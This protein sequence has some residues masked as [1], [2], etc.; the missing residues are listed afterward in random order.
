MIKSIPQI[1]SNKYVYLFKTFIIIVIII[2]TTTTGS[3]FI[4][5]LFIYLFDNYFLISLLLLSLLSSLNR[6]FHIN[7]CQRVFSKYRLL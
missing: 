1:H 7:F 2:I 5:L 3:L 6:I 4:Y